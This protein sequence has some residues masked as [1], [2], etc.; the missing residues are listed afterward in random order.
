[1]TYGKFL[2]YNIVGALLWV[3]SLVLAGY[4]F[5]NMPIVEKNFTFVVFAIII[6]SIIPAAVEFIKARKEHRNSA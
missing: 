4:F 3:F 6:I 1:M 2:L 5:G